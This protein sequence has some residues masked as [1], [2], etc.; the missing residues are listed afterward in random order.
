MILL[1]IEKEISYIIILMGKIFFNDNQIQD[2]VE[3]AEEIKDRFGIEKAL[4]Y[5]IGEKF[6]HLVKILHHALSTIRTID[7]Q[8]EKPDYNPIREWD[9]GELKSVE[10]LNET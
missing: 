1:H 4:G 7:A 3:A 9:F 2:W 8:R 10:N 6:Y 5:V